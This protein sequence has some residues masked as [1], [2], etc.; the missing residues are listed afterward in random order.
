MKQGTSF[1]VFRY[2]LYRKILPVEVTYLNEVRAYILPRSLLSLCMGRSCF[3][4]KSRK[5]ELSFEGY[6][7][8]IGAKIQFVKQPLV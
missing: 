6:N 5:F 4:F 2:S 1:S 3:F 7:L 8:P